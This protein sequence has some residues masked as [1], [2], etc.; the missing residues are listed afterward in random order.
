MKKAIIFDFDGV[1]VESETRGFKLLKET[2]LNDFGIK[3]SDSL[4]PEKVG[5]PTLTF[6]KRFYGDKL[7]E[8]AIESTY[9]KVK[10]TIANNLTDFITP[11][12]KVIDFI[13]DNYKYLIAIASM[14]TSAHIELILKHYDIYDKVNVIVTREHVDEHK[15]HPEVYLKA[16]HE[17]NVSSSEAVVIEDTP[18]GVEAANK[19]KID[20]I[21]LLNGFNKQS[22]FKGVLVYGYTTVE[23]FEIPE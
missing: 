21:V 10:K 16:L 7:S 20:C 15:P 13:R 23:K 4:F 17:L 8:D 6:L 12:N 9:D 18:V 14:N 3:V 2:L 5:K 11:H 22:D 19:A 1:I